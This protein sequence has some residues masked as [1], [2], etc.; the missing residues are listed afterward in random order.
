MKVIIFAGGAG[1]RLWP[2]SRRNSPK[3][4]ERLVGDKSTLQMAFDRVRSLG[5]ENIYVS[6]NEQY[7][8]IVREQLPELAEDRL[9][10]EPCKRDV[11][12]AVGLSL[13]RLK[14]RGANGPIAILWSDH[15][16]DH[17][18]IFVSALQAGEGYIQQNSEQFVFLAET[19]RFANHN[20]G[21]IQIGT[22]KEVGQ[23]QFLGWKYRPDVEVCKQMFESG[24]WYW[25]PGYFLCDLDFILSLYAKHVPEMN[26]ALLRMTQDESLLASEYAELESVH[27]DNAI[28]EKLDPS[29]VLKVSLGWSDP[30]TLYALKE[31]IEPDQNKNAVR[32]QV[33]VMK[34]KDSFVYNEEEGKL[35]TVI[36]LEGMVVINTKDAI[37]VCHKDRVPEIKA[38]LS[39][40]DQAGLEKYL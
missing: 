15:F 19:P 28:L 36:G 22:E 11:A 1:T 10:L 13:H 40:V 16:M 7:Q 20:L 32:G 21:W 6:T 14:Q 26:K 4:F 27:F 29:V 34:S 9:F 37:L 39:E 38:L 25:N 35:L 24:E 23:Y 17:P 5:I 33:V 30:G 3:Q 18:D 31:A 2:L 12:A 8:N